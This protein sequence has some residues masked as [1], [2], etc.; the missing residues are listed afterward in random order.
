MT[1]LYP[2]YP[3]N[4]RFSSSSLARERPQTR[5][6]KFALLLSCFFDGNLICLASDQ[7]RE[8]SHVKYRNALGRTAIVPHPKP[9]IPIGTTRS[10]IRQSGR[11]LVME[12]VAAA[13]EVAGLHRQPC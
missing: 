12:S 8:G 6:E 1:R 10:I 5:L 4:P 3:C 2:Q 13:L 9:E 11:T 7:D